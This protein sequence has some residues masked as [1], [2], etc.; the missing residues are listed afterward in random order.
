MGSAHQ[1]SQCPADVRKQLIPEVGWVSVQQLSQCLLDYTITDFNL[2]I[3]LWVVWYS[4]LMLDLQGTEQLV[5]LALKLCAIINPHNFW[6]PML[7]EQA[8]IQLC[9]K[10]SSVLV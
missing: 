5:E 9:G 3:G 8:R 4:S 7:S 6:Y 1:Y 10:G 2:A